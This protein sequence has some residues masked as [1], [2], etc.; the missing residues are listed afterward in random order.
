MNNVIPVL[1]K[2]CGALVFSLKLKLHSMRK[3]KYH[4]LFVV[5]FIG[6][7]LL[8]LYYNSTIVGALQSAGMQIR[9]YGSNAC[10][11]NDGRA[12]AHDKDPKFEEKLNDAIN[13]MKEQYDEHK[14]PIIE[15]M[16]PSFYFLTTDP[17]NNGKNWPALSRAWN[18]TFA[19]T[20]HESIVRG[21]SD[22][23]GSKG[24]SD[25]FIRQAMNKDSDKPPV[26]VLPSGKYVAFSGWYVGNFGHFV[27][28]HVSK[29]AWL[30][31][32]VPDDTKFLLPY[33]ELHE[34]ILKV[35]DE[36]FV[37]DR[38][39]WVQYDETVHVTEGSLTVMKPRVNFPFTGGYPQTGT[40]YTEE[41]RK[42]LKEVHWD[43][44]TSPPHKGGTEGKVIFYT[45]KGTTVRRVIEEQLEKSLIEKTRKVMVEHGR[46][47]DDLII[48]S[49]KDEEG[50]T[51]SMQSQFDLFSSADIV[52]GPH[53]S[54]LT[55][56]V[57]MDPRCLKKN[58]PKV[59]E[60][61]SSERSPEVQNG[62]YWGYWF[63]FGSLSWI[64]YHQ[65]YYT[66]NS[67]DREVY[68]DPE[69]FEKVLDSMLS[70]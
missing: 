47:E 69:I 60:F 11:V 13:F 20:D 7:F 39:V 2:F 36:K 59:L 65:L 33:H 67:D 31:S 28:D 23:W 66:E 6:S 49:G 9:G 64:D 3:L 43:S 38:I 14:M 8:I 57:W 26:R 37:T 58:R 4:R 5:M 56:V 17:R 46:Q 1:R 52:L 32:L 70:S 63:L 24:L 22:I 48:F 19:I 27:H 61:V 54:G 62:S 44:S 55:N 51:L 42:W 68:I 10:I 29:I 53:G 25:E 35:V 16:E 15:T 41:F 45:R 40:K 18:Q 50:N 21:S 34:T 30:K 12:V